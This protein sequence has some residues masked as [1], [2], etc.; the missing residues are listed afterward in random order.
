MIFVRSRVSV[1]RNS[2]EIDTKD[3]ELDVPRSAG[4]IWRNQNVDIVQLEA[5]MNQRNRH[6]VLFR[7]LSRFMED[8]DYHSFGIYEQM[9]E[10]MAGCGTFGESIQFSSP[11]ES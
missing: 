10:C 9:N 5:G 6:H 7:L 4:T 1:P 3:R 8:R 11:A 2:L